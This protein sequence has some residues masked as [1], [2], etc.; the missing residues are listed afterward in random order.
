MKIRRIVYLVHTI[1]YLRLA[2]VN[3]IKLLN[4]YLAYLIVFSIHEPG[5]VPIYVACV[6][7]DSAERQLLRFFAFTSFNL[8]NAFV[9]CAH[10]TKR[11][12]PLMLTGSQLMFNTCLNIMLVCY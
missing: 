1:R 12:P 10:F 4:T 2:P 9:W 7:G 8:P 3:L 6:V 11:S 5:R